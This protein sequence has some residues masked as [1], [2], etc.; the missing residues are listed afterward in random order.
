MSAYNKIS[1]EYCA[2]DRY[3]LSDALHAEW[4]FDGFV[5]SDW[6]RGVYQ[7]Y[8]AAAGLDI[9]NPEPLVF[10]GKFASAVEAGAIEPHVIDRAC[11]RIHLT[12]YRFA[13]AEDPLADYPQTL[14]ASPE[15][16]ALAREAAGKSAV[17]LENNDCLPISRGKIQRLAVLG[18]LADLKNTGDNGSSRVHAPYCITPLAGLRH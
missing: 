14:V 9:E 6:I 11:R 5:H 12:Q 18:R 1:G 15:P 13:T 7:P 3:L 8:G 17:L 4:G 10:G 2:Q 16:C